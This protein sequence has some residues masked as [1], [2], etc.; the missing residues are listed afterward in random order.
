MQFR[1]EIVAYVLVSLLSSTAKYCSSNGKSDKYSFRTKSSPSISHSSSTKT[2]RWKPVFSSCMFLVFYRFPD[3]FEASTRE[4]RKTLRSGSGGPG[5]RRQRREVDVERRAALRGRHLAARVPG[6][7]VEL[8]R[9]LRLA[10]TSSSESSKIK[11]LNGFQNLE[12]TNHRLGTLSC[13]NVNRSD[14]FMQCHLE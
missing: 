12:C 10:S 6:A 3:F 7:L 8:L 5:L 9:Q 2:S 13:I 14:F 1:C 4:K 11:E